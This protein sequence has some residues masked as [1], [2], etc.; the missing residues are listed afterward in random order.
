[1]FTR[2]YAV[3]EDSQT[4]AGFCASVAKTNWR[5]QYRK[6]LQL[7]DN[8]GRLTRFSA[9]GRQKRSASCTAEAQSVSATFNTVIGRQLIT[10]S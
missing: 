2:I 6:Y 10:A 9:N 3:K 5:S 8:S 7:V 4:R 1:M